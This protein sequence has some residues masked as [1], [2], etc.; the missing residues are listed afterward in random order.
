[1]TQGIRRDHTA[2]GSAEPCPPR[3]SQGARRPNFRTNKY[4][5]DAGIRRCCWK[6]NCRLGTV[7]IIMAKA[8]EKEK[9][10]WKQVM[11]G[12]GD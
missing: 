10:E 7:E 1:M 4:S 5:E 9:N 6:L 8:V 11:E 2:G 3:T 12:G